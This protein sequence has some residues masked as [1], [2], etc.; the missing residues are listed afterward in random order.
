VTDED[1]QVVTTPYD[2]TEQAAYASALQEFAADGG[3]LVLTDG[4]L[5]GLGALVEELDGAVSQGVFYA[6][7]VDF[8][9]GDEPTFDTHPMTENLQQ[10]GTAS[11]RQTLDG[12]EYHDRRQTYEPVPMGYLVG[13]PASCNS[14][15]DAPIWV[16]DEDA[17]TQ[18]GGT[19]L[20]RSFVRGGPDDST[21]WDGVSLGELEL[22]EGV[23][24]I[25]G[26][27]LPEPTQDNFHPYGL[28]SY[29]LT[30]TGYQLF[31]NTTTWDNPN[32][33]D[34]GGT[35]EPGEVVISCED[36]ELEIRAG[37]SGQAQLQVTNGGE[38]DVDLAAHVPDGWG[39]DLTPNVVEAGESV[40]VT[41]TVETPRNAKGA[42]EVEV[43]A[44]TGDGA[45]A[46]DTVTVEVVKGRPSDPGGGEGREGT[47]GEGNGRPGGPAATLAGAEAAGGAA[48]GLGAVLLAL[49]AALG[50]RARRRVD[51]ADLT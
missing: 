23:V 37:E 33:S 25:I 32:R 2:Q 50:A 35:P 16:V 12:E 45:V 40:P 28:A 18:A 20:G 38:V 9:D 48:L 8:N 26:A 42:H 21:G 47:P 17:W 19:H 36:C 46:A 49:A 13:A 10:D 39:A 34:D 3:N 41:L 43:V 51:R 29:G 22:G 27:L 44:R 1:D 11:G 31:E 7:Y 30:Y 24:R 6:G 15:C 14:G 4:A 5:A